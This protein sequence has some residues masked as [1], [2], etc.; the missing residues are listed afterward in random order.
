VTSFAAEEWFSKI[1]TLS[2]VQTRNYRI[3]V[4]AQLIRTRGTNTNVSAL[5]FGTIARRY[6]D[7]LNQQN[8]ANPPSCST[9]LL[10][11]VDY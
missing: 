5:S 7:V 10:R 8:D 6:Y 2:K 1:Y 9:Y 4:Q 3:Y 11:K